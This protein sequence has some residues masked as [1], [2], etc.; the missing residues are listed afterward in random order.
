[1]RFSNITMHNAQYIHMTIFLKFQTVQALQTSPKSVEFE[2]LV[3]PTLHVI[4]NDD[5]V[6]GT[7]MSEELFPL[8]GKENAEVLYHAGGHFVPAGSKT[9][10]PVYQDFLARMTEKCRDEL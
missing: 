7:K 1:M 3:I 2:Q 10:K 4:G 5:K 9:E 8:F 6:I